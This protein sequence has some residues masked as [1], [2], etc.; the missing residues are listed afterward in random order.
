MH[1]PY[2]IIC[3]IL[4]EVTGPFLHG[5]QNFLPRIYIEA[6]A[7]T[8]LA[9]FDVGGGSAGVSIQAGAMYDLDPS[10]RLGVN[11]GFHR[12]RGTDEGTANE[13]RMYAYRSNLNEISLRGHYVFR[14]K[15]YPVKRWKLHLEPRIW[16]GL[17]VIQIQPKPNEVL[18]NNSTDQYLPVAPLISGGLGLAFTLDRD[19]S[20]VLEAGSNLTT[21]DYLE[22][23]TNHNYSDSRDMFHSIL[24]KILYI[25][26]VGW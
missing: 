21:S 25:V 26:P 6:G 13:S 12:T 15:L 14:F 22:G 7:G 23:Y 19:I 16:A 10:W 9:Y 8:N 1:P 3:F 5:Q 4:L 24:L 17:G 18:A 11:V 2:C 20:L